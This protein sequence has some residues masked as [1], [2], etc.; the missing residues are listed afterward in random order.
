MSNLIYTKNNKRFVRKASGLLLTPYVY[1]TDDGKYYLGEDTYD[2]YAIVGDTI[3]VAQEEGSTETLENEFSPFA[4]I[5]NTTLGKWKFK[6]DCLDMQNVILK[7][8]FNAKRGYGSGGYVDNVASMP[9]DYK[10]MYCCVQ[11]VFDKENLRLVLP[12]V[13]L[14]STLN[15]GTLRSGVSRNMIQGTPLLCEI[16][17]TDSQ[18][19][20]LSFVGND[21]T[22]YTPRTPLV[23]VPKDRD[24][25]VLHHKGGN[26]NDTYVY[27]SMYNNS[28]IIELDTENGSITSI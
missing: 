25:G 13:L 4:V 23:F 9:S 3:S 11:I 22:T 6:A 7:E 17:V 8:I 28:N 2:I 24:F 14:T 12:K 15:I 21:G 27:F 26:V 19:E 5:E 16:C 10:T 18:T 20:A 1:N